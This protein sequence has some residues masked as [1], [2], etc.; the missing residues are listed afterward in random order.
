[1][2]HTKND[3]FLWNE[4]VGKT[5]YNAVNILYTY[6]IMNI[7]SYTNPFFFISSQFVSSE[8]L[9]IFYSKVFSVHKWYGVS[10]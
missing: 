4:I 3:V 6:E 1:M 5:K 9:I 10:A 7:E 2:L 8:K